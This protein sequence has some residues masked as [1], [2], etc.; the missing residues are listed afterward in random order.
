VKWTSLLPVVWIAIVALTGCQRKPVGEV[1]AESVTP[2]P[3]ETPAAQTQPSPEPSP[4]PE[5][6]KLPETPADPLATRVGLFVPLTGPQASFGLDAVSGAKLAV[7]EINAA[8]GVLGHPI[9]LTVKDTESETEKVAPVVTELIDTEKVAALIG[10]ITTDRSLVA[11]P[12]AQERGIPMITPGATNEKVTATGNYVFRTCYTDT[13]QAAVM[14]KFA[15]SLDVEKVAILYDASNTYGSSLRDAFKADFLKQEG[16]IV[17]EETYRTGDADFSSQ[18]NAIKL[19]NPDVVFLP[20]YYGDAALIIK[21]ARQLGIDAPFL[22]TDA[23][24]S[25]EFLRIGG[26]AVNNC[27]FASHFSSEHLSDKGKAFNEAYRAKVQAAPPPLAALTYDAV[28]LVADALKRAGSAE[29]AAVRDALAATKDFPG[30]TGTI[31]MGDDRNPKKPAVVIRVQ[32]GSFTY[33]EAA[34]P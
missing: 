7:E 8:G 26:T 34:G 29:P 17:A 31:T 16:S 4:S 30:V 1:L 22:G 21:Q 15:R 27:Y 32:D 13:F 6:L 5:P 3:L 23:W 10:E 12:I 2:S 20:S 11:A 25:N 24:D 9:N 19:K 33:L 28:W 14:T 18:L